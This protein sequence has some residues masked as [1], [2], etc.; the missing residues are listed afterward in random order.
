MAI[1]VTL[2]DVYTDQT[3]HEQP[4]DL[5]A[6]GVVVGDQVIAIPAQSSAPDPMFVYGSPAAAFI[7]EPA[8]LLMYP[9]MQ[10]T[11]ELRITQIISDRVF[12][13]EG[14]KADGTVANIS[15]NTTIKFPLDNPHSGALSWGASISYQIVHALSKD[16]QVAEVAAVAQAFDSKRVN[17]IWPD[18]GVIIDDD[19]AQQEVD[20][21]FLCAC[22]AGAKSA[23]PA[24]QSF[25]NLGFPGP[26][27]L[28]HSND[29]LTKLQMDDLSAAGVNVV[30]QDADGAQVYSRHQRTT[31]VSIF[32]NSELSIVTAVD[33]V[34]L[35]LIETL[36][37][38][39]GKYNITDDFLNFVH[40]A[41]EQY[42]FS[43]KSQKAPMCGS[44]IIDGK[45]IGVR[46]NLHGQ[47]QDLSPGVV[48][49]TIGCEFPKPA[50]YI[51][52][53]LLIS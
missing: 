26:Y 22:F 31:S 37:P 9:G 32:E 52:I 23:Y 48:E 13:M 18:K 35:D 43:A 5:F 50:N 11:G 49:L 34:S 6:L 47:N 14:Y 42:L 24:Q 2:P 38:F 21:T 53:K 36:K 39:I 30:V 51:N 8:N 40:D 4:T 25:T 44:L 12:I 28:V 15:K 29:Y 17:L 10:S 46:A 16:D 41:S 19:G 27:K 3:G 33:K 7:P 1:Q 20:G 45:V